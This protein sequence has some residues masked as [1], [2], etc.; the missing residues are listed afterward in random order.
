[1]RACCCT[2]RPCAGHVITGVVQ[3]LPYRLGTLEASLTNRACLWWAPP[4]SPPVQAV[5]SA[6]VCTQWL[7]LEVHG[8]ADLRRLAGLYPTILVVANHADGRLDYDVLATALR[9]TFGI[10][11]V[12]VLAEQVRGEGIGQEGGDGAQHQATS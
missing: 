8:A 2:C 4:P 9:H 5:Y 1:M 7:S 12:F 11:D 3:Q 6:W 10:Q